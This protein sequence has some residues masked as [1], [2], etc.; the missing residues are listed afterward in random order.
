[1]YVSSRPVPREPDPLPISWMPSVLALASI[2]LCV[3]VAA[4]LWPR[5]VHGSVDV[6]MRHG[7]VTSLHS[8][9]PCA[10][11]MEFAHPE[12]ELCAIWLDDAERV[13]MGP[14]WAK[15]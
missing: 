9:Q 6:N 4:L 10:A 12:D 2:A 14:L 13:V 1:M 11:S 15:P 7:F 5:D 3:V 8:A